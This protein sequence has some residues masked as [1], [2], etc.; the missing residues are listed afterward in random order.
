MT[1]LVCPLSRVAEVVAARAPERVISVLDPDFEFPELG[2]AFHG[3][4][5]RLRFHDIHVATDGQTLPTHDHARELIEFLDG[6]TRTG[7]MLVHCRA[8]IGRSTAVAFIAACL[9][10]P[11]T[12]ERMIAR[13]LRQASSNARPNE[14]L[15]ALA[16]AVLQRDGRMY[17]AIAET[18]HGLPWIEVRENEPFEMPSQFLRDGA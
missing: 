8:G 9:H 5:L 1:I 12:S 16:D 13:A 18:G 15:V 10:N 17:R 3:R 11:Y 6:W 4:H 14:T 2:G 7:P